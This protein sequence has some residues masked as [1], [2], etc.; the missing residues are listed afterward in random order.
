MDGIIPNG[1][2]T[3]MSILWPLIIILIGAAF[4]AG[5]IA[6]TR[7]IFKKPAAYGRWMGL[8]TVIG[9][10][11]L[12]GYY[13]NFMGMQAVVMNVYNQ[14]A[15]QQIQQKAKRPISRQQVKKMVMRDQNPNDRF[16][17]Q[18]FVAIPSR[19]ILL[20]IYD[21][22]YSEQGLDLGADFANRTHE[23]SKGTKVP[24][25]GQ[26]N[27][28]LAAHNFNDG[29]T[30]FSALQEHLN[31]NHPYIQNG[32]LNG[33]NWLNGNKIYLANA[34][35]IYEYVIR[36]QKTVQKDDVGVLDPS[37]NAQL[38]IISCLFPSTEYRIVTSADLVHNY[39]WETAPKQVIGYFNLKVQN[40]H[41]R[42]DWYNPGT[43]E[44]ANGDAGGTK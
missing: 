8:M 4:V 41:A 24:V 37:Q 31:Q 1:P 42:A 20:P 6:G 38:T 36:G 22:A 34:D 23:D 21:D 29:Q 10:V 25:M 16:T 3:L 7:K 11:I 27:Y 44:G 5:I 30:G 32:R 39:S 12:L 13:T 19:A 14:Q 15:A 43:E 18:G 35:G 9:S 17:K 33:S 40:T 26:G 2:G 28:G